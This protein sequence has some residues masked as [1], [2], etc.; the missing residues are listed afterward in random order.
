MNASQ[1]T[2]S[3]EVPP[4]NV[5]VVGAGYAGVIAANRIQAARRPGVTVTVVNPRSEFVERVRL[6]QHAADGAD[7]TT[8]LS[9]LLD[10]AV[11]VRVATVDRITDAAVVLDDGGSLDFDLLVYAVGSRSDR[12]VGAEHTHTVGDLEDA[13]RLRS[14]LRELADDSSVV[15]VGGGLTGIETSAE[16][17]ER[18][19]GRTVRLVSAGPVA[20]GLSE[21]GRRGVTRTLARL[22]VEVHAGSRMLRAEPGRVVLADGTVLASD[23]TIWAGALGV[24]DLARRS[25]LPV[26]GAGRLQTDEN[27]VCLGHPNV[28]GVGDAV[29]PPERVAGHIRMSC[30]A[31]I[32]LGAH[33]ADTALALLDGRAPR[34]L[35]IGFASQ[36]IS[37]GR[38]AGVVQL[39]RADD[40]P[41][42]IALGGRTAAVVKELICRSARWGVGTRGSAVRWPVPGP[43]PTRQTQDTSA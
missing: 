38:R 32:P 23:C 36:C 33:G 17:A 26:D 7:A 15:V 19:P 16:I 41:R 14:R 42:R 20:E 8:A 4:R 34:P 24:P 2:R 18:L 28:I 30:Q 12:G 13:D 39:V 43:T 11:R 31:A 6:H 3:S 29:A 22:G 9:G 10:P 1:G 27:L 25:G 37:L 5:V 40:S 35:S 21:R